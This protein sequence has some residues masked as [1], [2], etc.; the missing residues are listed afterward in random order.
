MLQRLLHL[1]TALL[2]SF[3]SAICQGV[4]T[5]CLLLN[6]QQACTFCSLVITD[7]S[8]AERYRGLTGSS[9]ASRWRVKAFL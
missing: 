6:L 5:A 3:S 2:M 9:E 4:D 7:Y 1:A 8:A